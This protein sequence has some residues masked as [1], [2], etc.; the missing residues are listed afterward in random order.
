LVRLVEKMRPWLTEFSDDHRPTFF[1]VV[2]VMALSY[3]AEQKCD[4][5]IWETGLGGR[6]DAT[7]I[8]TP[9]ASVITNVQYDH[10]Q[11]LGET[12]ARIAVEKAGIIKDHVPIITA[13]EEPEAIQVI[14]RVAAEKNSPLTQITGAS[15]AEQSTFPLAGEHQKMNAALALATVKVLQNKIPVSEAAIHAGL[16]TVNWP[17]RLQCVVRPSGQKILLDGAHNVAGA[18]VLAAELKARFPLVRP[19]LVL[20]ILQ[21]KNWAGMCEVL[22]PLAGRILLVPVS[23]ERAAAPLD[24]AEACRKANPNAT[25]AL[26]QSLS[27]VLPETVRDPFLV[28]AG[29]LYLIGEAMGL[30]DL[31]PAT[32]RDERRLNEWGDSKSSEPVK[33]L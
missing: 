13:A 3:F 1:E 31:L 33:N 19:T 29:S 15:G 26:H 2:T 5:V 30:L 21:D 8:V 32:A 14:A 16:A 18:E 25:I 23:S 11:W 7:N 28:I 24:L 9:L 22:A 17:G 4:L 20:G 10:Q 27:E 6:L 12:L